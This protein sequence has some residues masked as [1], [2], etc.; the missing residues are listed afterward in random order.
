MSDKILKILSLPKSFYVCCRL[1]GFRQA[2]KLPLLVKYNTV[3]KSLSGR[4][5]AESPG[6]RLLV[7]FGDVG[8]F[9][10]STSRS[11][12]ELRGCLK[13]KGKSSLGHGSKISIGSSGTL[14]LGDHFNN[15]AEG[16]IVCFNYIEIG[17]HVLTSWNSLI[18]DT[19]FHAI[20]DLHSGIC[21][22]VS[23]PIIIGDNVW[24]CTRAVVLKG[25]RIAS[26]SV[27]GAQ[28]LV[29]KSFD[30]PNSLI[31]GNPAVLVREAVTME[32]E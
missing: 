29:N 20:K 12:L 22:P 17:N 30:T 28:A 4:V 9:D 24:I 25:V 27:V 2:L 5:V 11:I 6:S 32:C 31:A 15:T 8:I 16:T 21:K 1:C 26:G 19:D 23:K 10:K 3:L 7:G 18:M 13:L 14:I